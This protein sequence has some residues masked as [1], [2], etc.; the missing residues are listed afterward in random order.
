MGEDD[1]LGPPYTLVDAIC[2]F[3]IG[4]A[5]GAGLATLLVL[6]ALKRD[7]VAGFQ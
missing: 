4:L 3:F 2:A 6:D 5:V 1:P 7:L